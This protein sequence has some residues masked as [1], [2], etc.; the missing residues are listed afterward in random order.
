M[1][2]RRTQTMTVGKIECL[3]A[4]ELFIENFFNTYQFSIQ[5]GCS[6][7]T[8]ARSDGLGRGGGE[9]VCTNYPLQISAPVVNEAESIRRKRGAR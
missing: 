5:E 7:L 4:V 1:A 8:Y 9:A 6:P 3:S 2:A